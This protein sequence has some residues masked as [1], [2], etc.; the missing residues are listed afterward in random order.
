MTNTD[1]TNRV[2]APLYDCYVL[3]PKRSAELAQRFLDHFLPEREPGFAPEDPAQVLGLPEAT[4][5]EDVVR[6]LEDHPERTYAMYWRSKTATSPF[7]AIVAFGPDGCLVLGLSPSSE[8]DAY[9]HAH[10]LAVLAEMK[11]FAGAEPGYTG[12]EEPPEIT[13]RAFIT[14]AAAEPGPEGCRTMN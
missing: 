14:R 8:E 10:A 12:V 6:Y 2:P 4:T 13:R 3:A 5:L 9:G 1:E 7:Y 11:E